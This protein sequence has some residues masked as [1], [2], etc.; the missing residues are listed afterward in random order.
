MHYLLGEQQHLRKMMLHVLG[1][2]VALKFVN[3]R[4][5]CIDN[6]ILEFTV[7]WLV[8]SGLSCGNTENLLEILLVFS[9]I[10]C[11]L[12]NVF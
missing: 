1:I 6:N 3:R 11:N 12:C 2:F 5:N 4:G 7:S 10:F 8:A 9:Q